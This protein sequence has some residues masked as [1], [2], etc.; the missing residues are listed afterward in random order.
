MRKT[1]YKYLDCTSTP[2][3]PRDEDNSTD[4]PP[5]TT[6]EVT[7]NVA[8][9]FSRVQASE[10]K[11]IIIDLSLRQESDVILLDEEI[12]NVQMLDDHIG[13]EVEEQGRALYAEEIKSDQGT[14]EMTRESN[15]KVQ[16]DLGAYVTDVIPEAQ[17]GEILLNISN[18]RC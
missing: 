2:N 16:E 12:S 10:P 15:R 11:V 18:D 1:K 6:S 5:A 4:T 13:D 17:A 8:Q 3:T 7:G 14:P 9:D